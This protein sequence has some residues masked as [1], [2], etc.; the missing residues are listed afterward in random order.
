LITLASTAKPFAADQPFLHTPL[1]HTLKHMPK[2]FA[3]TE[4]AMPVLREGRMVRHR[5]FQTQATEPAIR[6]IE[7]DLF[8]QPALGTNAQAVT[9][10][11]HPYH[12]LRVN[13]RT[14]GVAVERRQVAAQLAKIEATINPAQQVIGRNVIVEIE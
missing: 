4:A 9:H 7:V 2:R 13:R 1:N 8:A 12:Q 11:Q 14:P 3:L 5:I 10:D 6:Q